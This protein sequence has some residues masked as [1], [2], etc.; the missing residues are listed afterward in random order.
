MTPKGASSAARL[1]VREIKAPL[2]V[3][4][5]VPAVIPPDFAAREEIFR[6]SPMFLLHILHRNKAGILN[7]AEYSEAFCQ[8]PVL[9]PVS[10]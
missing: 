9:L 4:Y 8:D 10:E 7:D 3:E 1:K 2:E 5:A 6:I